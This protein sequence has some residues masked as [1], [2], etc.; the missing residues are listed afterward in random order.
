LPAVVRLKP[1]PTSTHASM[2]EPKRGAC[3]MIR[4]MNAFICRA[5]RERRILRFTY[6]AGA[7]EI[8]PYCHGFSRESHEL[9]RGYQIAGA[10]RSGEP[11]GWKTFRVDRMTA[12]A[13]TFAT[14][15]DDRDGYD[16]A[17]NR[18]ATVHCCR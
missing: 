7:R 12:V 9:V 11:S 17:D 13:V 16:P 6:D 8:E 14:C 5:I 3:G 2:S 4:A 10:S 18:M 1:D 15:R